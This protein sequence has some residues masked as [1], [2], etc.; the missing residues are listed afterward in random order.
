[1]A[2]LKCSK[3]KTLLPEEK[4]DESSHARGRAYWCR[5]CRK[6]FEY[7]LRKGYKLCLRCKLPRRLK[8]NSVCTKCNEEMGLKQCNK[9]NKL[10]FFLHFYKH[11]YACIDC[12][13]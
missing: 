11:K 12:M 8:S 10:L 9:C 1:M 6:K 4:F 13:N 7:G 2:K 5:D 3:C